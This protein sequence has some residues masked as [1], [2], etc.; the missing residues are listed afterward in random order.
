MYIGCHSG[1]YLLFSIDVFVQMIPNILTNIL[2]SFPGSHIFQ[3]VIHSVPYRVL[4]KYLGTNYTRPRIFSLGNLY[5]T[6]P[7]HWL[8]VRVGMLLCYGGV[9]W[10]NL[11]VPQSD[12]LLLDFVDT[13]WFCL[14]NGLVEYQVKGFHKIGQNVKHFIWGLVLRR[15]YR[16]SIYSPC[17]CVHRVCWY[18]EQWFYSY[19]SLRHAQILGKGT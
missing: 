15:K 6:S 17:E 19:S 4:E 14:R 1:I 13:I 16:H 12:N 10:H 7:K 18:L 2:F 3:E 11:F 9:M 8:F 5:Q